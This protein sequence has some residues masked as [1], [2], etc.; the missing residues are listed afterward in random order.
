MEY[1]P[2][3]T[4]GQ[5]ASVIGMD[6]VATALKSQFVLAVGDNFYHEGVIDEFDDRFKATFENVYTPSSL[7]TPWYA[8]LG[9][10]DYKG[11]TTAQIEYTKYSARWHLP[12]NYYTKSFTAEDGATIDIIVLDTGIEAIPNLT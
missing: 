9:N 2:Y 11:N 1:R 3:Y 8:V 10:H 7:Q 4:P 5:A 12:T 6:K